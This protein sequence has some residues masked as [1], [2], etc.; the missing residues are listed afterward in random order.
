MNAADN[1]A[2]LITALHSGS[3]TLPPAVA[4]RGQLEEAEHG[5]P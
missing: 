3:L 4:A 1:A 5:N 2:R